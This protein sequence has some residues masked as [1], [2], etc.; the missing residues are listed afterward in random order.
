MAGANRTGQRAV[1]S[2]LVSRSSARPWAAFASRSAV[3][4]ATTT[5]SALCPIRTCGTSWTSVQTSVA[6]GLPDRAAQV[7]APTNVSALAVGTTVTS[8]PDSVS[9]RSS[10]TALYAAMPPATPK[11]TR[12]RV[13][14]LDGVGDVL[15]RQQ[16]AVDL[17]QC[18][19]QRLLLHTGL[20]Q[21]PDVLKQSLAELGVVGVDLT[22]PL[23][24]VDDQAV[25]GVGRGQQLVD[26]GVGDA[27]RVGDG[28][29]Q[30]GSL[31][32]RSDLHQGYQPVGRRLEI[33]VDHHDVELVLRGHLDPGQV[34]PSPHALGVLRAAPGEPASQLVERRWCEEHEAGVRHRLTHQSGALQLDL[35]Q[36]G[37]SCGQLL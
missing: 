36:G 6:T 28:A 2:V 30:R 8:W 15:V 17:A 5:R 34:E 3:A 14:G 27:D 35:E 24:R 37:Y 33:V 7:G 32:R 18:D 10:S 21:R 20:H 26:R 4:G 25:L 29:G 23:G 16:A 19:R 13:I 22:G 11:T 12:G 1:S 9:C 31:K